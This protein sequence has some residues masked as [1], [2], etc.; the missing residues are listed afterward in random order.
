[1]AKKRLKLDRGGVPTR[2][3]DE[4]IMKYGKSIASYKAGVSPKKWKAIVKYAHSKGHTVAGQLS[5]RPAPL[6]ERT[7][8]SLRKQAQSTVGAAYKPVLAELDRRSL[9]AKFLQDKRAADDTAYRTWMLGEVDK[10]D[11]QARAADTTLA[12]Q[13]QQIATDLTEAQKAARADSLQRAAQT[14]GNVSDPSQST[15]LDQTAA[16]TRSQQQVANQRELTAGMTKVGADANQI[17]RAALIA[18]AAVR[19]AS[20]TADNWKTLAGIDSDRMQ[21]LGEQKKDTVGM[22]SDLRNAEVTKAQANREADQA[23]ATLGIKQAGL[24]NTIAQANRTYRLQNRK[25]ELD[26]WKAKNAARVADAKVQLGYDQIKA[27]KGQKAADR[28]LDKWVERYRAKNKAKTE[29]AKTGGVDKDERK[30]YRQTETLRG[31]IVRE[32]EKGTDPSKIRQKLRRQGFDD[33]MITLAE[34]LRRHSGVPSA[35][36]RAA[37]KRIGIL[38]PGYFWASAYETGV[39]NG[40]LAGP[41]AP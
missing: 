29:K 14:A 36:G 30:L 17:S 20:R 5:G 41:P 21:A 4:D 1:M 39:K 18:T 34:D 27:S 24:A 8:S 13:Q 31:L 3:S 12:T 40:T 10:L 19:E 38:H 22:L 33:V 37:A 23:D 2:I 28:A 7:P 35:A 32:H 26:R 16:D 15:A 11:A 25:Y 9:A 6:M